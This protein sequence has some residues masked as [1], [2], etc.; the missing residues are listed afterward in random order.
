MKRVIKTS[1]CE[2][3]DFIAT[4]MEILN[5]SARSDDM[6]AAIEKLLKLIHL[7]DNEKALNVKIRDV[8]IRLE[9]RKNIHSSGMDALELVCL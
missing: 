7:I 8:D 5:I 1:K 6:D 9:L 4:S 3:G 2:E